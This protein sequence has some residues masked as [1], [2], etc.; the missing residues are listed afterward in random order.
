MSK[1]FSDLR[2]N[3]QEH[4]A[5]MYWFILG[6][7]ITFY[8]VLVIKSTIF[9]S[10]STFNEVELNKPYVLN[11]YKF[12]VVE[13]K[14]NP[15]K[16]LI[17]IDLYFTNNIENDSN[18]SLRA[19]IKSSKDVQ[20]VVQQSDLLKASNNYYVLIIE[21][22]DPGFQTYSIEIQD[23]SIE[24]NESD[25]DVIK[26]NSSKKIY[27]NNTSDLI[28][29]DLKKYKEI[30]YK[31]K[32]IEYEIKDISTRLS[33]NDTEKKKCE[34]QIV[35]LYEKNKELIANL[36]YQLEP[37]KETTNN[38]IQN[39]LRKVAELERQIQ[40]LESKNEQIENQMALLN[41]KRIDMYNLYKY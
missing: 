32:A 31:I 23:Y 39:N 12:E 4:R 2:S 41:K 37:Q 19:I 17:E 38:R 3:L 33:E 14:Y 6:S 40:T 7:F 5:Y 15:E 36:E 21:N 24:K 8:I 9:P 11:N 16:R 34:S 10:A 27:V 13:K 30:G 35:Y 20:K 26:V 18:K 1:S 22:V 25:E 28:D 29:L